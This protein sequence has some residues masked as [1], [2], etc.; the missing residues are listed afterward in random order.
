MA[1]ENGR[2]IDQLYTTPEEVQP[3][4]LSH[5]LNKQQAEAVTHKD[6]PLL[7]VAGAG[8]GKTRVITNRIAHLI[9]NGVPGNQILAVT[10]TN[11]AAAEMRDRVSQLLGTRSQVSGESK[12][13][14]QQ[15]IPNTYPFVGTFHSLGVHILKES[16]RAIG[17]GRWFTIYDRDDSASLVRKCL[18]S[19]G[20]DPKQFTP[21]SVLGA[22]SRAKGAMHTQASFKESALPGFYTDLLL[23]VWPE[24]DRG[25]RE[26]EALDFDDLLLK[27]A[28]LLRDYPDVRKYYQDKWRYIHVDEF[29]DTNTVQYQMIRN[30]I[31]ADENLCV[32]GDGDQCFPA[33]TWVSTPSGKTKIEHVKEG[34]NILVAAGRGSTC[35]AKVSKVHKR[36]YG[37]KLVSLKLS[38]G[39]KLRLTPGHIVFSRLPEQCKLFYVYLMYRK[40]RGFR[41]GL[42]KGSRAS[43]QRGINKHGLF[44]RSN[45]EHADRMWILKACKSKVEALYWEQWYAF[46][47]GIPQLV[48]HGVGRGLALSEELLSKL[49]AN[50]DTRTRASELM[51]KEGLS[52]EYPHY[53][54][55]G[56]TRNNAKRDRV[57]LRLTLFSDTRRSLK[58]P[59]GLSRLSLN[60]TNKALKKRLLAANF[61][62]RKGKRDDWRLEI[63]NL[64][65]GEIEKL[66]TQISRLEPTLIVER[67]A[68]LTTH[69]SYRQIP[70]ES[71]RI[72]MEVAVS[73]KNVIE[74]S[75]IESI[76]TQEYSGNVF[77]L[78]VTAVHNY[79]ANGVVVHNCIY[80][81]RGATIEN[82]AGFEKDFPK[83]KVVVLEENYR[84]TGN[85][86]DAAN[87]IIAKNKERK[88]K[89]LFTSIGAGDRITL[90]MSME[91]GEE[92]QFVARTS[93]KLKTQNS[94]LKYEDVAVLYRANF[95]SRALEEAFL[96]AGLPY[97]VVGTRFFDRAEIK[98]TLAYVKAALNP[99]DQASMSRAA[100]APKRG[101]GDKTLEAHFA[102]NSSDKM[103]SF[104]NLLADLREHLLASS[105]PDALKYVVSKSGYEEMLKKAGDEGLERLENIRELINLAS[106]YKGL[107]IEEALEKFLTEAGLAS[108]QDTLLHE[109]QKINKKSGVRLMTVHAAKG[110][111][112]RYVFIVGL[113]QGLFPHERMDEEGM[114]L[115]RQEEERRLFYVAVTRAKEKLYLSYCQ[116]RAMYGEQRVST[117]SEYLSDI[118]EN[119]IDQAEIV[120]S[121]EYGKGRGYLPDVEDIT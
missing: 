85:I 89:N 44:V 87:Q 9:K 104:V 11:K 100:G 56:T 65:Y 71:L 13:S 66:G 96:S 52:F 18:K 55:Q 25:L 62:S 76:N 21:G 105:L 99:L 16:G 53:T 101:L 93:A 120:P 31:S 30:L 37:D 83:A 114:S 69:G 73:S 117:P 112:F 5:I 86:L 119:L 47:Y 29:Q 98:D 24:Y 40:D 103:Q 2:D 91:P 12:P 107:S 116:F 80:T 88:E 94:D 10:F 77:D 109:E 79:I 115:A 113:E 60:T 1:N 23:R 67:A 110:L 97:T 39:H 58:S 74:C 63:T 70:A 14:T 32:V 7:V 121:I 82:M 59:W 68:L 78:D 41:I 19:A 46:H 84:S 4:R 64:D 81:W 36:Q 57:N 50:I 8:T 35:V 108:D 6:G 106:K 90:N 43:G 48:F 3:P 61:K 42:V 15:L 102:G 33:G 17:V 111:E 38:N 45:Q 27:A 34:Q 26:Q 49:F 28:L 72:G 95:Q 92:A 75:K 22:I 20:Y 118:D 51:Q 54:P